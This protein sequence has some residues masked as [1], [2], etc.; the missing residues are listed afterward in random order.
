VDAKLMAHLKGH[1]IFAALSPMEQET[2]ANAGMVLYLQ[3]GATLFSEGERAD[4]FYVL[5]EG[6]LD[7]VVDDKVLAT[8]PAGEVVG[9][10]GLVTADRRSATIRVSSAGSVWHLGGRAFEGLLQAG[11]PMATGILLGIARD[12]G[13]R[14][15]DVVNE[16]A[17]LVPNVAMR[18]GGAELL[19]RLQWGEM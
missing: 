10:M 9:E 17:H 19:E 18:K 4:G 15:R 8:I 5:L 13:R 11:D 14:F 1:R 2:L 12:L 3:A 6:A 16:A 7:V